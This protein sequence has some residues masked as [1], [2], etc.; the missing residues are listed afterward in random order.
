[1]G[2]IRNQWVEYPCV[3][4][5][6]PY[7]VGSHH[8]SWV[9]GVAWDPLGEVYACLSTPLP[10]SLSVLGRTM[11]STSGKVLPVLSSSPFRTFSTV[12]QDRLF[13]VDFPG[14][15]LAST[16]VSLMLMMYVLRGIHEA[17]RRRNRVPTFSPETHSLLSTSVKDLPFLLWQP[18]TV[19]SSYIPSPRL[20][21]S[22]RKEWIWCPTKTLK[23][24]NS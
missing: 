21:Q 1:M 7:A 14:Q 20:H 8:T 6:T 2:F 11:W 17:S 3:T 13:S 16:F 5:D 4:I 9:K 22:T 10:S 24:S 15:Y 18:P 12:T 23:P 19:R